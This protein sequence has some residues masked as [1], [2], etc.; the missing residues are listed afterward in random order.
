MPSY[1]NRIA[2]KIAFFE[3]RRIASAR[4]FVTQSPFLTTNFKK[5]APRPLDG[6]V[7]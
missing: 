3:V 7:P 1:M 5:S 4:N 2:A 6:G